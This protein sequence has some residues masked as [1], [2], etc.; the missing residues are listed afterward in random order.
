MV[1][2]S[3][4][5][6]RKGRLAHDIGEQPRGRGEAEQEDCEAIKLLVQFELQD[7]CAGRVHRD[8]KVCTGQ[9]ASTAS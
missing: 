5:E 7:A 9:V 6:R 3:S 4:G 8:M 1:R 2:D